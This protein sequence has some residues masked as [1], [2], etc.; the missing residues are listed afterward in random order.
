[1]EWVALAFAVP[2]LLAAGLALAAW[3]LPVHHLSR[4]SRDLAQPPD[5]VWQVLTDFQAYPQWRRQVRSIM[6]VPS[7]PPEELWRESY[8]STGL[9]LRTE[10][11][12]H[13]RVLLRHV[14]G[15]KLEFGGVWRFELTPLRNGGTRLA[16]VEAAEYYRPLHRLVA[17]YITGEGRNI[18]LFLADLAREVQRQE[19]HR[20]VRHAL[21]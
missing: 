8:G 14:V 19:P 2:I 6:R 7:A 13:G 18:E 10:V 20:L 9:T 11:E 12:D 1:L 17:R 16:I 15:N 4:R 5:Q 3:L 21:A